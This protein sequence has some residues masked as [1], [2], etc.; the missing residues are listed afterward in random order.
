MENNTNNA[1]LLDRSISS[2]VQWY[3]YSGRSVN[4]SLGIHFPVLCSLHMVCAIGR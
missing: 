1:P 4:G 2:S 3:R